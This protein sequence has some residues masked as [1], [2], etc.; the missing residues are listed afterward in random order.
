VNG[1][2]EAPQRIVD[3]SRHADIRVATGRESAVGIEEIRRLVNLDV[4]L[5]YVNAHYQ[6]LV[7]KD[8]K[9]E[10]FIRKGIEAQRARGGIFAESNE[11]LATEQRVARLK[12]IL[13]KKLAE[14][15]GE[16]HPG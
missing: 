11:N 1:P 2:D 14:K 8:R 16:R 9:A 5:E 7:E 10:E 15:N 12:E 6:E 3:L 4:V 13:N